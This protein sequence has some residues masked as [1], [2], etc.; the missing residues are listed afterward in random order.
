MHAIA[1]LSVLLPQ[2]LD[3]TTERLAIIVDADYAKLH[4]LG[5]EETWKIITSKFAEFK[6]E[7]PDKPG[8][9]PGGFIYKNA[10]GLPPVSLWIMPNNHSSGF[11]E[12]FIKLSIKQT[13]AKFARSAFSTVDAIPDKRFAPL[14]TSK[15]E[16]ATWLAWQKHPG[17]TLA[18]A[19]GD[20]LLDLK[21][22]PCK[23][24]IEWLK[25]AFA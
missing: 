23:S 15:A 25:T 7:I 22:N 1:L 18:S 4:G 9:A 10:D 6:Y 24:F 21:A 16:I 14:H 17:K 11:L 12:D 8:A 5:F 3:G 19:I 13:E 2:L 20:Q